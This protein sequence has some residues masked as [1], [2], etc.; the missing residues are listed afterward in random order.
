[1]GAG[2][3]PVVGVCG[4][5]SGVGGLSLSVS[6]VV[7]SPPGAFAPPDP[8]AV[9]FWLGAAG[10]AA[11]GFDTFVAGDVLGAGDD[12][13]DGDGDATV[14]PPTGVLTS[15]TLRGRAVVRGFFRSVGDAA[16]SSACPLSGTGA[17]RSSMAGTSV[18][19]GAVQ[20]M[21]APTVMTP[22]MRKETMANRTG[23]I[24]QCSPRAAG[25]AWVR[26]FSSSPHARL[27]LPHYGE[28][29][30]RA[31]R[32]TKGRGVRDNSRNH[33]SW[34]FKEGDAIVPG[35]Y[36]TR[37]LGGGRR[38]EAYLAWDDALHALVVVKIVRP[39][40]V[41]SESVRRGIKGEAR[42]LEAL[43]HPTIVRMFDAE[44]EGERPHIV[45][46]H[47]EGPRLSTLLR[48][49]R[50]VVEQ[51]LPL[52]LELCSG[53]HYMHGLGYLHLDVK[54][55]NVVMSG[56]PRLIDLSIAVKTDAVSAFTRP[57]GTDAYMAPEQC[58]PARFSEIGPSS[59]IWGLGVTMYEAVTRTL[60]FLSP[61]RT[62]GATGARYPQLTDDPIPLGKDV[63]AELAAAIMS[64]LERSPQDR[65]TAKGL[66]ETI[67]PW[68]AGLP[69]PRLGLFR[70]GGTVRRS[71]FVQRDESFLSGT[72]P[73]SHGRRLLLGA[74]RGGFRREGGTR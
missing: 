53:L 15:G 33:S 66:A 20:S 32:A 58:D 71:G 14:V 6:L 17:A 21:A 39:E 67:E 64:C 23:R 25:E 30:D 44:L 26:V 40:L 29:P 18:L 60:P 10:V 5:G 55:R 31:V 45:L 73:G 46:E 74:V 34:A 13:G 38:Y 61:S 57:V 37:L 70:P 62:T 50:I 54:P 1:M 52:A 9:G 68:V 69:A 12:D 19:A 49:Y 56:R 51:L 27:M 48:R 43:N 7:P 22:R 28:R 47:L 59:D 3:A 41:D 65:P 63:P 36:A 16:G 24:M 11:A 42:A 8:P 4:V 2:A 35:R 72:S